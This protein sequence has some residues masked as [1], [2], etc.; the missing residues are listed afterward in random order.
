MALRRTLLLLSCA[1]FASSVLSG[2]P[3]HAEK[4]KPNSAQTREDL[5]RQHNKERR[6]EGKKPLTLNSKLSAAAQSYADYLAKSGKFSHTAKGTMSSRVKDAGYK[7]KAVGENIAVGQPSVPTVLRSWMHSEG[8][9]K[10]IL[11]KN[12]TEVGF[13]IARDKKGRLL[14]V[15]DFGDR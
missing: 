6:E 10:N 7:P 12:Y 1:V 14:W 2:T 3:C 8:H 4:A 5:L 13:G 11:S 9:K 15:T